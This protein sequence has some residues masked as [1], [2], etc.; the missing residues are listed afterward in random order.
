MKTTKESM[1]IRLYT[2][3]A[4][5]LAM[6]VF[7]P[8]GAQLQQV[9]SFPSPEVANLSTFGNIPVG[10]YTGT[11]DI[12]VPLLSLAVGNVDISIDARYHLS[13]V[14]PH[15]PP[16]CLGI[17]WALSAGGYIARTVSGVQD[18]K[19]TGDNKAGYYYNHGKIAELDKSRDKSNTLR[20]QTILEGKDWYEMGADEFFF[21]F[22][23][24]TG[25][26][27]LDKD[28]RWRVMSDEH[29]TVEFDENTGLK[30]IDELR[31]R[32]SL[33]YYSNSDDRM[34]FDKFTLVTPDGTRYQFGGGNATEYS[35]P[36]Y[37]QVYGDIIATCWRLSKITTPQGWT[38]NF[39]YAADSYMCNIHYAPQLIKTHD[40][41]GNT[42]Q[43]NEG[44][45]G[46]SG[47]LTMPSRLTKISSGLETIS[48]NYT[49]DWSYGNLFL[50]NTECLY[51]ESKKFDDSNYRYMHGFIENDISK[52]SFLLFTNVIPKETEKATNEAIASVI[53]QD[54]LSGISVMKAKDSI[55]DIKF[56][57]LSTF[58]NK[59]SARRLLSEITFY[60]K[61][62][63]GGMN[64]DGIIPPGGK[65]DYPKANHSLEVAGLTPG[66]NPNEKFEVQNTRSRKEYAYNF[67]Y[68][69]DP[70]NGKLWP[71]RNPLTYTDSWGY[72]LR[73]PGKHYI[74]PYDSGEWRLS[75]NTSE[76]DYK[77]RMPNLECTK[78][79]SL[80]SITYPTGGKS[81]FDY[82]LNDYSKQFDLS[83]NSV[84]ETTGVAGGL[85]VK[86]IR[87]YDERG[88][89]LYSQGYIYKDTLGRR[90]SG[91]SKGP[92]RYYDKVYLDEAKR[93][94]VEFYSFDDHA[95]CPMNFNTP[96]VGYSTVME[97]TRNAEGNVLK[98]T[99]YRYTNFDADIYGNQ[100]K[101]TGAEASANVYGEYSFAP[102]S[103]LAFER[104][105]LVSQEVW[106]DRG[107]LIE[108]DTYKYARTK[109]EP[110]STVSQE[111]FYD[112]QKNM[113]GMS[114]LYKT[115]TNRYLVAVANK[116]TTKNGATYR[117][118]EY[119]QYNDYG[120][121]SLIERK[122]ADGTSESNLLT[123]T[124]EDPAYDWMTARNIIEPVGSA[125]CKTGHCRT[126]TYVYSKS[127]DSQVPYCSLK[128]R[129][130]S[131]DAESYEKTE[132]SV[133][134]TDRYGNP[135]E[136]ISNGV[137]T[138]RLWAYNGQRPM[139]EIRGSSYEEVKSAL[140]NTSP[141]SLSLLNDPERI[142]SI[143]ATL[144]KKLPKALLTVYGW[145]RYLRLSY[146]KRPNGEAYRYQYDSL[147][148]LIQVSRALGIASQPI[149][150]YDYNYYNNQ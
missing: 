12:Q 83:S 105:R 125:W 75:S 142:N 57:Y 126:E 144:E 19:V 69:F 149:E 143:V 101:D 145:D 85:R 46:Y 120:L 111:Y 41:I 16:T 118:W 133:T 129:K 65:I 18:E 130:W 88:T 45:T 102:F 52:Y 71:E 98:R 63:V 73:D 1:G 22:N 32:F 77:T 36:Y 91:I 116:N 109:G 106:D 110:C 108:K 24:H 59:S 39:E 10:H 34:L 122:A 123:Y 56:N 64:P 26:F 80:K 134:H 95:S 31:N 148:R 119:Y 150:S 113:T 50:Q 86:S 17:G 37:N 127:N 20:R 72:F 60:S 138:V 23:G 27:F 112:T 114:Y 78:Q 33:D 48:F 67:D 8:L 92:A 61:E 29:I 136:E 107:E 117:D 30:T 147:D 53:T 9:K 40:G 82:E 146:E 51:W 66:K 47:F 62:R 131:A 6:M 96:D 94:Y 103:S 14:K 89:T 55:L 99:R 43:R 90:S 141:E 11:P 121:P 84:K 25:S 139:A 2:I 38:A 70:D 4:T 42:A 44:R 21:S 104:G 100:H 3:L 35:V 137:R 49:R 68:Y 13:N 74:N 79:F 140:G 124:Y 76:A 58:N 135:V 87:H 54:Y 93:R 115:Y 7:Q 28:G 128:K 81:V 15:T 5:A 97:E 132:L